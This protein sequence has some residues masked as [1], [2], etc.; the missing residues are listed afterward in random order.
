MDYV[1]GIDIG[2]TNTSFGLVDRDGK[3]LHSGIISSQRHED[4]I[5]F[6][7]ELYHEIEALR[8]KMNENSRLVGIG[9]GAPNGN[10]LKGTIEFAPNL[11]WKGLVNITNEMKKFYPETPVYLTNDAN[12]AAIGEM[13][14]GGAKGMD[15]FVMI[16]LGTGLGSGIVSEGKLLYGY[17][18]LA[19]EIGHTLAVPEGRTCGCGKKGCLETYVSAPG[20][21]RTAFELMATYNT[22]SELRN[23]TYNQLNSKIIYEAASSGDQIALQ[24]F[25]YTGKMLGTKLADTVAHTRPEAI[26]L[27][28]G[29]AQAADMLL[30]PTK[31]Y[32]EYHLLNVYK[33]RVKVMLSGLKP[34]DAAILGASALAW[35]DFSQPNK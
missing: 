11:P 17:D 1:V 34:G 23:Y 14:Y 3:I 10:H 32:M 19:G 24:C 35:K 13:I 16:T 5:D 27:F 12:A 26:F 31:K 8:V 22:P 2:G 15:N 25:E 20:I 29:L 7:R 4:P 30:V 33:G 18:G 28:G 21:K 6:L 9:I